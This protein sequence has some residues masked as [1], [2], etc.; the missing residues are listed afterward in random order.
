MTFLLSDDVDGNMWNT[1]PSLLLL[2]ALPLPDTALP[3]DEK[4]SE[5]HP[6]GTDSLMEQSLFRKSVL[7]EV[8]E[9]CAAGRGNLR[10]SVLVCAPQNDRRPPRGWSPFKHDSAF[11]PQA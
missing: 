3:G 8:H 11:T 4:T 10:D 1:L 5:K 6:R 9:V 2:C 7:R